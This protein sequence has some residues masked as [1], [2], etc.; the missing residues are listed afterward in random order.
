MPGLALE[1]E[2]DRAHAVRPRVPDEAGAVAPDAVFVQADVERARV[3]LRHVDVVEA[4]RRRRGVAERGVGLMRIV[5][6]ERGAVEERVAVLR[7]GELQHRAQA[8]HE[9]VVARALGR[10][11][12]HGVGIEE[13]AALKIDRAAGIGALTGV[14]PCGRASTEGTI[15]WA[16][17]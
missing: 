12:A 11:D 8:M 14:S 2:E 16:K 4:E 7:L 1:G 5:P 13:I 10:Q 15:G 3:A 9:P 6:G 17:S